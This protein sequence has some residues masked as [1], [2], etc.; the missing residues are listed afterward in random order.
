MSWTDRLGDAF[1]RAKD[2]VKIGLSWV[3]AQPSNYWDWKTQ[4][5]AKAKANPDFIDTVNHWAERNVMTPASDVLFGG[6]GKAADAAGAV[7]SYGVARPISTVAQIAGRAAH[8]VAGEAPLSLGAAWDRSAEISPGQAITLAPMGDASLQEKGFDPTRDPFGA[9]QAAARRKYFTDT[10]G[11]K[12]RSGTVDFAGNILLDPIAGVAK[13]GKA[14]SVSSRTLK[15]ADETAQVLKVSEGAATAAS[16]REQRLAAKMDIFLQKTEGMTAAEIAMQPELRSTSD[17]GALAYFFARANDSVAKPA[18]RLKVKRTLWGAALGDKDSIAALEANHARLA[19]EME[20]LNQAPAQATFVAGANGDIRNYGAGLAQV[21]AAEATARDIDAQR[22][23]VS[24]TMSQLQR[25]LDARGTS[26]LLKG[27]SRD[28]AQT[29][30]LTSGIRQT[31]IRDGL[32][33]QPTRAVVGATGARLPGHVSVKNPTAGFEQ[34]NE[35]LQQAPLTAETRGELLNQYLNSATA[36]D[37]MGVVKQAEAHIVKSIGAKY[38]LDGKAARAMLANGNVRRGAY[39]NLLKSRLYSAA[40]SDEF[41]HIVDPELDEGLAISKPLLRSQ[42]ED[43]VPLVDPRMLDKALKH[44]TQN[45]FMEQAI[46]KAPGGDRFLDMT[47]STL[48]VTHDLLAMS[49]R[50]WKDSMLFRAAYPARVQM[51]SQMRL[52][53]YLGVLPYIGQISTVFGTMGKYLVK[54][55]K[56]THDDIGG[57]PIRQWFAPEFQEE[58]SREVIKKLTKD[59]PE[60]FQFSDEELTKLTRTLIDKDGGI[61]DLASELADR[62]LAK[63]RTGNWG[64]V[65]T[66]DPNWAISYIR[67]VNNQ[68]R[69]SPGAM[70]LVNGA[71]P[72]DFRRLVAQDENLRNEWNELSDLYDN[73]I[74]SWARA[75]SDHVDHY[76]PSPELR[77]IVSGSGLGRAKKDFLATGEDFFHGTNAVFDKFDESAA[78]MRSGGGQRVR[79][80]GKRTLY[81]TKDESVARH[82]S[83]DSGE[84]RAV[85]PDPYDDQFKYNST[86]DRMKD[87]L[88]LPS[89][90]PDPDVLRAA[91]KRHQ[92]DGEQ[93]WFNDP[94]RKKGDDWQRLTPE[95]FDEL[96][97]EVGDDVVTVD[98]RAFPV[99]YSPRVIKTKVYGKTL[100]L[101]KKENLPPD[102]VEALRAEGKWAQAYEPGTDWGGWEHE[103]SAAL[104]DWA[105]KNGYGKIHVLDAAASGG[106]SFIV[107]PEYIGHNSDAFSAVHGALSAESRAGRNITPEDIKAHFD[108]PAKQGNRMVVHGESHSPT[109][110]SAWGQWRER[111]RKQWY[112][113]ASEAPENI[114]ARSPLY[115]QAYKTRVQE[116]IGRLADDASVDVDAVRKSADKLARKDVGNLLFDSSHASNMSHTFRFVAP[117]FAAWE[118]M[119]QKWS[120]LIYEKPWVAE[121]MRQ[122][123]DAPNNAGLVVDSNGNRVDSDGTVWNKDPQGNWYKLDPDKDKLL[124]GKGEYMVIPTGILGDL[125]GAGELRFNKKSFNVVFQGEPFWLPG[126]GPLVSVPVN[127]LVRRSFAAEADNTILKYVL[128]YGVNDRSVPGQLAPSWWRQARNAFGGTKDYAETYSLLLAQETARQRAGQRGD[129]A[130]GEIENMARN[131][132]ILRA[133]TANASPV[134]ATPSPK[135]AFYQ[136]QAHLYRQKFGDKDWQDKFYQDFPDYFTMTI[137]LN[138]NESGIQATDNSWRALQ[139]PKIRQA[140]SQ[141]PQYGKFLVGPDAYVQPDK[142]GGAYDRNVAT[143]LQ[144]S[145]YGYGNTDTFRGQKT[146][147]EALKDIQTQ[148]G[149][150]QYSK[151]RTAIN[152]ELEKR[153]LHS[154]SQKGAED[155]KL[156]HG[157]YVEAL[158][159]QNEAWA[160]DYA[161]GSE[162]KLPGFFSTMKSEMSKNRKLAE[163]SDMKSLSSYLEA[164]R[165]VQGILLTR[166]FKSV[167][168]ETNSDL[169]TA[170]D[171]Y[172][173]QLAANDFGFEQ[174]WNQLLSRDDLKGDY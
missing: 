103:G 49:T 3:A 38:G 131:W 78:K 97:S 154:M 145:Q 156:A 45:R 147:A 6:L 141:N 35:A 2:E 5:D 94:F 109:S 127:E 25:V 107:V 76:L 91:I 51:D 101:T 11:G 167:G 166:K 153:G 26:S 52:G 70:H 159:V 22:K 79:K 162:K 59:L 87:W 65:T 10:W 28:A 114:M 118:D 163:R 174:M 144:S 100:D 19:R 168:H 27:G 29:A 81:F 80:D 18:D 12:L 169:K 93:V 151:A 21:N 58:A 57:K 30:K 106:E 92:D 158:G 115:A 50:A 136:E 143:A 8:P 1:S 96:R 16:G 46:R 104:V 41:V 48:D 4:Q 77:D 31:V 138:T 69:N 74:E 7:Y 24:D 66:T 15:G 20:R 140:I 88:N 98:M 128:P 68:I 42:I 113:F 43:N 63:A 47:D 122:A 164:R 36:G 124:I 32:G 54:G 157:A 53:S 155:L 148:E 149:W 61:A 13:A 23:V 137:S 172:G 85:F 83:F 134:S 39:Q 112:T 62:G 129:I 110:K 173:A 117:F 123:W 132:F 89:D 34:L 161:D 14:L 33:N 126:T 40:E 165:A 111:S 130:P 108:G 55:A 99:G 67:A 56:L 102:L 64:T 152:L 116:I 133:V 9:D 171:V 135:L 170:L 119:M 84:G 95:K 37:R 142:A 82:F 17:G 71:D 73:D 139:D 146:P 150:M 60:E 90:T 44:A 125:T 86:I 105:R 120:G 160:V 75:L 121:R 72:V